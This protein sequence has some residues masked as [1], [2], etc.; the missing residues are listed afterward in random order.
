M[1]AKLLP[2]ARP[3]PPAPEPERTMV[4]RDERPGGLSFTLTIGAEA[5][6]R[7]MLSSTLL[8]ARS[9]PDDTDGDLADANGFLCANDD[10]P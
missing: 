1:T 8:A 4:T 5:I 2:F 9:P 7:A 3:A 6:E 10:G